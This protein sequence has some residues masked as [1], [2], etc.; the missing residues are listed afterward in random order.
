MN[1]F[2]DCLDH[3]N[4]ML[5][6]P[7]IPAHIH[8]NR[9]FSDRIICQLEG[10]QFSLKFRTAR[11]NKRY[12]ASLDDTREFF[13]IVS[14]DKAGSKLCSDS[15]RQRKISSVSLLKLLPN[16]GHR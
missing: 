8:T 10:I 14:L 15:T 12:W 11:H 1:D 2:S 9:S 6:L 13:A 3:C 16:R 5:R 7:N 4:R